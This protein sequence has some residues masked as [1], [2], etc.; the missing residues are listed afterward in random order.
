MTHR[1][2]CIATPYFAYASLPY[3]FPFGALYILNLLD[4]FFSLGFVAINFYFLLYLSGGAYLMRF[5][6][7][8]YGDERS[9]DDGYKKLKSKT[10]KR[11]IVIR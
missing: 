4:L 5:T 10:C 2:C 6:E 8:R 1:P 3:S 11:M 7:F 9:L